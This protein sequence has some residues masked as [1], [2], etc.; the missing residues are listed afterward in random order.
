[1]FKNINDSRPVKRTSRGTTFGKE[2]PRIQVSLHLKIFQSQATINLMFIK[3]S[4]HISSRARTYK[5][6]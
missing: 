1:M 2:Q 5:E 3:N 6:T 4:M